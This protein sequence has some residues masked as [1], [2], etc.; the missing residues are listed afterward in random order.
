MAN[1]GWHPD[2]GGSAGHRYWDGTQWTVWVHDGGTVSNSGQGALTPQPFPPTPL[3]FAYADEAE[4]CEVCG[5][6][7]SGVFKF[8]REVGMIVLRRYV[9][10]EARLCRTCGTEI[11]NDYQG[12]TMVQGWWGFLSVFVNLYCIMKNRDAYDDVKRLAEPM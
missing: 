1:V 6:K 3:R 5:R 9:S 8:R 10:V 4:T 11:Y 2:P 7:P 12:K